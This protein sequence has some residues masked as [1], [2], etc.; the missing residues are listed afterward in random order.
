MKKFL[1]VLNGYSA[2]KKRIWGDMDMDMLMQEFQSNSMPYDEEMS[3]RRELAKFCGDGPQKGSLKR[4][5]LN[6][7]Q[8]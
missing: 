7:V 3:V 6:K 5:Y 2:N 8:G 1:K 4:L